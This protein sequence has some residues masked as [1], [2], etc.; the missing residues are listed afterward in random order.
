V[1]WAALAAGSDTL[2]LLMAVRNLAA[3]AGRLLAD[4]L[5]GPTPAACVENA[6]TAR[7]R[8]VRCTLADLAG[9]DAPAVSNPAVIL[10]GPTAGLSLA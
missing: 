5:P 9:P 3:I 8:V 4:G 2:V 10:I 6:G 1:D 7:Q